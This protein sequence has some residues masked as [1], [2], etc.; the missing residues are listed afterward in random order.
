MER[1]ALVSSFARWVNPP[2]I[3]GMGD[4]EWLVRLLQE[5]LRRECDQE[6]LEFIPGV[7]CIVGDE[8]LSS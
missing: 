3:R 6:S 1:R 4:L 7:G 2:G 8:H 5:D